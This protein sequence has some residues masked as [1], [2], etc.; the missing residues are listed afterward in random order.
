MAALD[1]A[2]TEALAMKVAA[3]FA[4]NGTGEKTAAHGILIIVGPASILDEGEIKNSV[5]NDMRGKGINMFNQDANFWNVTSPLV[6]QDGALVF[7][8]A[9][10]DLL[11][12][13]FILLD[14]R[15]SLK[16]FSGG[17]RFMAA[18]G[19][20][21][22]GCIAV[23]VSDDRCGHVGAPLR[24]DVTMEVFRRNNHPENKL[25]S[26]AVNIL[27]SNVAAATLNLYFSPPKQLLS[28]FYIYEVLTH[29]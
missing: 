23:K 4:L 2:V 11:C 6:M 5:I 18:S 17:A 7:D 29:W 12:G 15:K 20:G 13:G 10:G 24:S 21:G 1:S 3:T 14:C 16:G 22:L 8:E 25:I 26:E 27:S 28:V 9:T 19:A